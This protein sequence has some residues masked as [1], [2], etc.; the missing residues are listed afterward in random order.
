MPEDL[1]LIFHGDWALSGISK[2]P[3]SLGGLFLKAPL[4]PP[5]H[6]GPLGT[7]GKH[8]TQHQ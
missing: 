2:P 1:R 4:A 8:Q 5:F 3:R 6:Q 7:Q